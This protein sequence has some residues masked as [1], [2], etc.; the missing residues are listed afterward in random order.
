MS[1]PRIQSLRAEK[2]NFGYEQNLILENAECLFPQHRVIRVHGAS[3]SGKSSVLKMIVGLLQ[4]QSGSFLINDQAMSEMSFEEFLPY[5]LQIGYSF[6]L[7][8]LLN[9]RTLIENLAL[10]LQ[11]HKR[12]SGEE[13]EF[14]IRQMLKRFELERDQR[15]RPSAVSGGQRK[16]ACVARAL[17][18]DPQV[19]VLDDPS[20]GLS[21]QAKGAL[22]EWIHGALREE[23]LQYVVLTSE[24]RSWYES[25]NTLDLELKNGKLLWSQDKAQAVAV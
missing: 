11:Y 6:D 23:K 7:G 12:F 3:G 24:D 21:P 20:T 5:R 25:L 2:L 16:A 8:G 14:R 22:L 19:L 13:I 15:Q 4:P 1:S 17:I 18:H 10:P 9:N